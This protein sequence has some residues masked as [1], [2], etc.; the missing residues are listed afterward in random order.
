MIADCKNRPLLNL[1]CLIMLLLL[2]SGPVLAFSV[3]PGTF[4]VAREGFADPRFR[5]SVVLL[6]QH[7]ANG[8]AGVIVNRPSRLPLSELVPEG[9]SLAR[10]AA[11]LWYGG[12][13]DP[14]SL[15]ALVRVRRKP[16][17]PADE[18]LGRL[19]LTGL[20]V[21]SEWP[22]FDREVLDCK[23][24]SGYA[25]WQPGQL[26]AELQRG[27]WTLLPVDEESVFSAPDEAL[28]E[29]LRRPR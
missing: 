14:Q 19:Y 5:D 18:I 8:S 6:I 23:V 1:S 26:M 3:T 28:W 16:P 11:V 12:P 25:G 2:S 4:L 21:L 27:D 9:S 10:D 22:L 15:L 13:V 24:F 29:R 20:N 7:D 17:E